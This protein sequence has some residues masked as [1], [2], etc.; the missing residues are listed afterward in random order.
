MPQCRNAAMPQLES[1]TW[2][3][4]PL[5]SAVEHLTRLERNIP[6]SA[7]DVQRLWIANVPR[8]GN[9][10]YHSHKRKATSLPLQHTHKQLT[11]VDLF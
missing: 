10:Q 7:H 8:F 4:F 3:C 11:Q 2:H 6:H 1:E 5:G 9:W